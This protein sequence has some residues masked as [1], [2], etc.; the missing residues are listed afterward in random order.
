MTLDAKVPPPAVAVA[1]A[2]IIWGISQFAPQMAIPA[3]IRLAITLALAVV[4]IACS[5]SGVLSF[6][7]AQTTVNPTKLDSAST[8]VQTGIYRITRNPMYLGLALVLCA[9]AVFLSSPWALLGAAAFVL[10]MNKFQIAPEERALSRVFGSAYAAYT[11]S[12]GRWL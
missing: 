12:V 1:A 5:V 10:Y 3:Y 8:L 4:G 9:W 7:Q 2:L 6:R 11:A